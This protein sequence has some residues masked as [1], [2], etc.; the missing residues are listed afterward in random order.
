MTSLPSREAILDLL[1]K[2]PGGLAADELGAHFRLPTTKHEALLRFLDSLTFQGELEAKDGQRFRIPRKEPK[3]KP[4]L[5]QRK[6]RGSSESE[7]AES[8]PPRAHTQGKSVHGKEKGRGDKPKKGLPPLDAHTRKRDKFTSPVAERSSREETSPRGRSQKREEREGTLTVNP[9]GFGFLASPTGEGD[10]VFIPEESMSGAMHGDRVRVQITGRSQKGAEGVIIAVLGRAL[11]R[12]GGILRRRGTSTWLEPDDPRIRSRIVLRGIDAHGA[13]GNSGDDGDLAVVFITQHPTEVGEN[14]EGKLI[15]VLGKPGEL[16]GESARALLVAGIEETHSDTAVTEAE[17]F[18]TTVPLPMLEGRVDLTHI[19]LPT[20]DPEDARDHDDAVWVERH[21]G[22][23]RAWIAI[24]DVSS[25]VTPGSALD[26]EALKRGCSVYLPDRA[27]PM[28]PRA[29]SSNLCSL[30]PDE[31]RLCLCVEAEIDGAGSVL[32]TK[33]HRGFMKSAAKL[34]YGGVARALGFTDE[35]PREP[36]AEAMVKDLRVAYELSVALRGRRMARGALDFNL[37]EPKIIWEDKKPVN[38]VRRSQDLGV[39]KAYQLIE[40]LMLLANEVVA[41][42]LSARGIP[43][44]FRVHL[45]PDEKKLARLAAYCDALGIPFDMEDATN[46]KRLSA[47]VKRFDALDQSAILNG[48]LL[49]SMKQA[50][51]DTEN[52]GHFGLAS[53]AYLHFT[54]PIRRYPDLVVHRAVHS[55]LLRERR[56]RPGSEL[57]EAARQSSFAERRAMEVE[58]EVLDLHRCHIMKDHIGERFMGRVSAIVGGGMYVTLDEPFVD[59]FVRFEDLGPDSYEADELGLR[60]VAARSGEA[61]TVGDPIEVEVFDVQLSRRQ[62]SARRYGAPERLGDFRDRRGG[63]Q[64]SP[65]GRDQ[66]RDAKGSKGYRKHDDQEKPRKGGS[67]DPR[68]IKAAAAAHAKK[69]KKAAK[70]V[71]NE[72]SGR[73]SGGKKSGAKKGRRR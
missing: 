40:E 62:I 31:V 20:I 50:T 58:R 42:W 32:S 64:R 3:A 71:R 7:L 70:A 73:A 25:Y 72:S 35:P 67:R 26:A 39:K 1:A 2:N 13:E 29:L 47:M 61:I 6:G 10:D 37:P 17:S 52:H 36:K 4:T 57:G 43:T 28:L 18:G 56:K 41:E 9:R 46:P 24:A 63:T 27:V 19:P 34:T 16:A 8:R 54:S 53:P 23:Y 12:V 65:K 14:P 38:V 15:A 11:E 48:L 21:K 44:I 33:V 68:G 59:V 69:G 49:R 5:P 66:G 51:Y 55:E 30:L 45:Q 60:A 22:G